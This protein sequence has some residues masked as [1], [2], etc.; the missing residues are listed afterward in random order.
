[1]SIQRTLDLSDPKAVLNELSVEEVE[2]IEEK[3][4]RPLA[5]IYRPGDRQGP[6]LRLLAWVLLRRE[7]PDLAMEDVGQVRVKMD[8]DKAEANGQ[9][10]RTRGVPP[11]AAAA[12]SRRRR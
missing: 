10:Q 9:A 6:L 4:D 7:N 12:S 2:L 5:E 1:M 11:T 8:L 3:M